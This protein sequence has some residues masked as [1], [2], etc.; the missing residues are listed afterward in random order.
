MKVLDLFAGIGGFSLAA[1]C[2][3]WETT[4]FVERDKFCQK[5][6]RKNFG[7]D[8][9]IHDDITSFS[10][11]PFHGR[12]DI[13]TGGFP[14]QPASIA[15]Q[16]K[17]KDDDRY[18]FPQ[19]L[20][21]VDESRP[22]WVVAENV[23]GL[24]S[25]D[26]G[27]LFEDVCS[28]LE[29]SG[30]AVQTFCIPATSVSAPHRRDRLW[31]IANAISPRAGS[32]HGT[33]GNKRRQQSDGGRE[34]LRQGNGTIGSSGIDATNSDSTYTYRYG[35]MGERRNGSGNDQEWNSTAE[36][37]E[38]QNEQLGTKFTNREIVSNADSQ[39]CVGRQEQGQSK[40][41]E[42]C[43]G[44][45]NDRTFSESTIGNWDE[46]PLEA[47][48]RLCLVDDGLPGGLVRLKGWRVNAL[49][50]AGNSIVPQ[51]AYRIFRAI[52]EVEKQS[53]LGS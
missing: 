25:V 52:E 51:I 34:A 7:Q 9:E 32:D 4:A 27:R 28:S 24:L 10:G 8:I 42:I 5:V 41:R 37:Q 20:R 15:G 44:R 29:G 12:V 46:P 21:V 1:H 47:A 13:V 19:M 26:D 14:C 39:R 36:I 53:V 18:L 45:G 31:I 6:L 30:Y 11:K 49:K 3:G 38:R 22:T 2:M 35:A 16:R 33:V 17:G 23:R 48:T 40:E 50:A 43:A